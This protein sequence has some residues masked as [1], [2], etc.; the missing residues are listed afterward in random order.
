[1]KT[2]LRKTK[3]HKKRPKF[4]AACFWDQDYSKLDPEKNKTYI[5]TRVISRGNSQDEL[6][7]FR[8]YGWDIIKE[9]VVKIRYL[10][11]KIFNYISKLLDIPPE[12]FRCFY[13]KG[14]F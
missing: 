4:S 12:N 7:L 9:E 14:I 3:N 6:E 8:F 1:M 13:N 11:K 5:I 2:E 10:N